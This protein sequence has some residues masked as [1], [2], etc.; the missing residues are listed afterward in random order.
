ML[1]GILRKNEKISKASRANAWA[2]GRQNG[3]VSDNAISQQVTGGGPRVRG[4]SLL[5]F[6][7]L[8]S[9]AAYD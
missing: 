1:L 2:V 6:I 5:P 3:I 9:T 8:P 7:D 4:R